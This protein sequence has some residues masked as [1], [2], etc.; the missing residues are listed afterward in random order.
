[1]NKKAMI[2]DRTAVGDVHMVST[3]IRRTFTILSPQDGWVSTKS[4][5][6]YEHLYAQK[7]RNSNTKE[8]QNYLDEKYGS[9]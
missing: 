7:I 8:L 9:M 3:G 6:P 4:N 1:M 2:I 5:R